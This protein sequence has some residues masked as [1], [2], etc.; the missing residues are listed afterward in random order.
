MIKLFKEKP[1]SVGNVC[2]RISSK[3]GSGYYM[4]FDY[5]NF[6]KFVVIR[7]IGKLIFVV[8]V[9]YVGGSDIRT[10]GY[11]ASKKRRRPFLVHSSSMKRIHWSLRDFVDIQNNTVSARINHINIAYGIKDTLYEM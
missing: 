6:S 3:A 11:Y 5:E 8:P 7:S 2:E 10:V 9:E 1:L 4:D